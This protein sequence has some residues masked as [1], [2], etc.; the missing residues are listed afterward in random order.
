MVSK[1]CCPAAAGGKN[2]GPL[3]ISPAVPGR[4]PVPLPPWPW[5][6][7]TWGHL[8]PP[9]GWLRLRGRAEAVWFGSVQLPSIDSGLTAY[10]HCAGA[11][12]ERVVLDPSRSQSTLPIFKS[13]SL[14][15]CG[16]AGR[17]VQRGVVAGL[18][19]WG[20]PPH[21]GYVHGQRQVE[22]SQRSSSQGAEGARGKGTALT[23]QQLLL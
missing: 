19:Q 15:Q 6:R 16:I 21:P 11:R 7:A 4:K 8:S 14:N 9:R 17:W 20:H 1:S 5:D 10:R 23:P 13:Q 22:L 3:G 12:M 2:A 18:G